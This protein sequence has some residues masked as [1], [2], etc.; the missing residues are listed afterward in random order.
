MGGCVHKIWMKYVSKFE[1]HYPFKSYC[2]NTA[3]T[4]P[5]LRG[6]IICIESLEMDALPKMLRDISYQHEKEHKKSDFYSSSN[7]R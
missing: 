3:I 4:H 5:S 7:L 1:A 6:V 2:K